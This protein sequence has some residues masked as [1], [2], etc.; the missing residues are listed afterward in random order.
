MKEKGKVEKYSGDKINGVKQEFWFVNGIDYRYGDN[1]TKA[2]KVNVV[3][4][5]ETRKEFDRETGQE[6][7]KT[8]KFAWISFKEI[9]ERNAEKRC[10]LMGRP[11]WNIET[12]NLVEK[13]HGYAYGH[14]FSYNWN[15]M[16]GYHYLMHLG[17]IIN[18]LTLYSTGLIGRLKEK[19]ARR[20]IKLI[21]LAFKGSEL[22]IGRLK[23]LI[24]GKYQIRLAI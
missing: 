2:V 4:C 5:M 8:K 10:N 12:Q 24:Q 20:T 22:D 6:V 3:V 1:S 16:K 18:V 17:H 9:N 11:R 15:A 21:W 19:G 14:C 23:T 13:H 7:E